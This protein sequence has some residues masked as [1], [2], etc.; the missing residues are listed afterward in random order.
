V[1]VKLKI[2][3]TIDEVSSLCRNRGWGFGEDGNPRPF[4]EEH[5]KKIAE[6]LGHFGGNPAY[7]ALFEA[8]ASWIC[9]TLHTKTSLEI[10]C[11]PGYLIECMV[12]LG[13]D[14]HGIDGNRHFWND[15]Q[16]LRYN[17]KHRYVLDAL[18]EKPVQRADTFISIEVFE[19][20]PDDRLHHI[21]KRVRDEVRPRFI[22][23]SSTP[24]AS[25]IPSWDLQWGHI[26]LKQ[27]AEWTRFFSQYGFR[28][29]SAKP[30]V[31]EWSQL[32]ER[33]S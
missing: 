8:L 5:F 31:T 14:A 19:H 30:P 13:V 26:N 25:E 20:I 1:T 24:F 29:H 18:F 32:Y 15:F 12:R 9:N 3:L 4:S 6:L 22:V 7:R 33:V 28:L 16:L 27:P 11:G 23:F 10:G 2:Y 21:M 17:N